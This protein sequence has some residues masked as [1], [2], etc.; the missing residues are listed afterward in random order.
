[1]IAQRSTCAQKRLKLLAAW[2]GG[3]PGLI[4]DT[5]DLIEV[6]ANGAELSDRSLEFNEHAFGKRRHAPQVCQSAS[7]VDQRSASK[8]DQGLEGLFSV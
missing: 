1:M 6:P 7:K 8:T 3:P 2:T 5:S 4:G